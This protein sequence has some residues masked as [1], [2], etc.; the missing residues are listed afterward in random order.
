MVLNK[1]V[2]NFCLF[3]N[4][5]QEYFVD[6]KLQQKRYENVPDQHRRLPPFCCLDC[7]STCPPAPRLPPPSKLG[8]PEN[9][10]KAKPSATIQPS[11]L[12]PPFNLLQSQ[13]N[14]KTF[15]KLNLQLPFNLPSCCH[16][17]TFFKA[18][19]T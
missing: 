11:L 18:R 3:L 14:L 7:H 9:I 6:K 1:K 8:Q 15:S 12:L 2:F 13:V 4:V 10:F 19:S 17:S 16:P 5:L